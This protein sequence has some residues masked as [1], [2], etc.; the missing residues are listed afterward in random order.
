VKACDNVETEDSQGPQFSRSTILKVHNSQG[1]TILK[2]HNSQVPQ[3]SRSTILKCA[4]QHDM[5]KAIVSES[6][7]LM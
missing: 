7:K 6:F 3:F 1:L 5:R 4:I 2:V